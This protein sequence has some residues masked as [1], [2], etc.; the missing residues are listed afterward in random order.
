MRSRLWNWHSQMRVIPMLRAAWPRAKRRSSPL[1]RTTKTG[2]R[3]PSDVD[4]QKP[5]K[6][7]EDNCGCQEWQIS[8]SIE[9]I[10]LRP[11]D[12]R[13]HR[14]A[15]KVLGFHLGARSGT[16]WLLPQELE[17]RTP[18]P[19]PEQARPHATKLSI[20]DSSLHSAW[21][22][23]SDSLPTLLPRNS[24]S[25]LLVLTKNISCPAVIAYVTRSI[26]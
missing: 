14:E 5:E 8:D 11:L 13:S 20:P 16:M 6:S 2:L 12:K 1:R 3:W 25:T 26:S 24:C 10:E 9:Q 4:P 19:H 22:K 15:M 18:L 7:G 23:W 21:L 17:N